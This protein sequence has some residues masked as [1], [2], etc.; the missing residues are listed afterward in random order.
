L[1]THRKIVGLVICFAILLLFIVTLPFFEAIELKF[2]NL[3]YSLRGKEKSARDIVI[4]EIDKTAKRSDIAFL[5]SNLKEA[6][7]VGLIFPL[8]YPESMEEDLILSA[9]IKEAGNVY[10]ACEFFL[11]YSEYQEGL[12][13]LHPQ[14]VERLTS[15]SLQNLPRDLSIPQAISIEAPMSLFLSVA[16]GIGHTNLFPDVNGMISKLPLVIDYGGYFYPSLSLSLSGKDIREFFPV[17]SARMWINFSGENFISY[18][19]AEFIKKNPSVSGK[20]VLVGKSTKLL[21]TPYGLK[22]SLA[23]QADA[24]NNIIKGNFFFPVPFRLTAI[25]LLLFG[26]IIGW[27]ALSTSIRQ[28]G[29]ITLFFCFSWLIFSFSLFYWGIWLNAISIVLAAL[30]NFLFCLG[31]KAFLEEREKNMIKDMFGRYVSPHLVDEI[32]KDRE[33]LVRKKRKEITIVFADISNFSQLVEEKEPEDVF[34]LLNNFFDEMTE[35]I[36]KFGGN[37][38]KF[39][40]D[41]IMFLFGDIQ[42]IEDRAERGILCSIAM[43]KKTIELKE[44]WKIPISL[45]IGIAE[46]SV[47]I[48]CLGSLK[49]ANYTV[50]GKNVNLAKSLQ[51]A[52]PPC[53]ILI[54]E[55]TYHLVKEKFYGIVFEIELKDQQKI[56]AY[57]IPWR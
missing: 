17:P 7:A 54:S 30:T 37:I 36:S 28:G 46:G 33:F 9:F 23:I 38:D 2:L 19:M 11:P 21:P 31:F 32:L 29:I 35:I 34:L 10:L 3:F 24:I 26:F 13:V 44:K 16:S 8:S 43:Q 52:C 51:G 40:G 53:S 15:F 55:R 5:I 47:V 14:E 56:L 57:E 1:R 27:T 39:I 42:D 20:I 18:S 4:I 41:G 50:L 6:K 45:K 49:R 25:L 48:G 12:S 22:T